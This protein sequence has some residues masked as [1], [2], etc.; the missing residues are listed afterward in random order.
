[1]WAYMNWKSACNLYSKKARGPHV[2]CNPKCSEA[3]N[4]Q[5]DFFWIISTVQNYTKLIHSLNNQLDKSKTKIHFHA[6][7][8]RVPY[9]TL[10]IRGLSSSLPK[11]TCFI[12]LPQILTAMTNDHEVISERVILTA[13]PT[14]MTSEFRLAVEAESYWTDDRWIWRVVLDFGL[15]CDPPAAS[16][17]RGTDTNTV[18]NIHTN[19]CYCCWTGPLMHPAQM[20]RS[21][22]LE[23]QSNPIYGKTHLLPIDYKKEI[24]I[25]TGKLSSRSDSL[26]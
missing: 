21:R 2:L 24:L 12:T 25:R 20:L 17:K 15:S 23:F 11:D 9:G 8:A 18:M 10:M 3:R 26:I 16:I 6:L 14:L 19:W 1:M 13:R 5:H 4:L 7:L 22:P